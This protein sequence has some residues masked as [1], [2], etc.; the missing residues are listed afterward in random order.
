VLQQWD[1]YWRSL[2]LLRPMKKAN[3]SHKRSPQIAGC[4]SDFNVNRT[5]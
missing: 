5:G 4:N 1:A 3:C 2:D